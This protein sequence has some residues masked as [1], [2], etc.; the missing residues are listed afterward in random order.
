MIALMMFKLVN[1]LHVYDIGVVTEERGRIFVYEEWETYQIIIDRPRP[2][3]QFASLKFQNCLCLR[4]KDIDDNNCASKTK[5]KFMDQLENE[6]R[7]NMEQM[8][9]SIELANGKRK[10]KST[11]PFSMLMGVIN[12][13]WNLINQNDVNHL[14]KVALK[15]S[16]SITDIAKGI[17]DTRKMIK[18]QNEEIYKN[19]NNLDDQ[20]CHQNEKIWFAIAENKVEEIL[21]H[22]WETIEK[23]TVDFMQGNIPQRLEYFNLVHGICRKSCLQLEE[24]T[25]SQY[26]KEILHDLPE[27]MAPM[28]LGVQ[29]HNNGIHIIIQISMPTLSDQA[30]TLFKIHNFGI[31]ETN[32]DMKW[33]KKC[34][35]PEYAIEMSNDTALELDEND[36][37]KYKNN[38]ICPEESL[39]FD[40]CLSN[41]QFCR[42]RRNP[43]T[44]N[45]VYSRLAHGVA[46]YADKNVSIINPIKMHEIGHERPKW[47]GLRFVQSEEEELTINCGLQQILIPSIE[48]VKNLTIKMVE[49]EHELKKDEETHETI[50]HKEI[51]SLFEEEYENIKQKQSAS[52]QELKFQYWITIGAFAAVFSA[53]AVTMGI[54][55][56]YLNKRTSSIDKEMNKHRPEL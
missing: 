4:G 37:L 50:Q 33:R 55:V 22:Y 14:K 21:Q 47:N 2:A 17:V 49:T 38:F 16:D 42:Y 11:N 43:T 1:S 23:E 15:N 48:S 6:F 30:K 36:C 10:R 13:G 12:F 25:C 44:K 20:I 32:N 35:L 7:K 19:I 26:C 46:I 52:H 8:V 40:S 5:T 28:L 51:K 45:C 9:K 27:E 3:N 31:I 34:I 39:Y 54:A 18:V 24:E 56:Y 41:R 29:P 53:G